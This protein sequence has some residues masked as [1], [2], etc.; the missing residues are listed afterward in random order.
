MNYL[1]HTLAFAVGASIGAAATYILVKRKY[2]KMASE[3]IEAMKKHYQS[4]DEDEDVVENEEKEEESSEPA[5]PTN[6]DDLVNKMYTG[7]Y[8]IES[9]DKPYI[10]D[11]DRYHSSYHGYDKVIL[12]YYEEDGTL[13]DDDYVYDDIDYAIGID[14]L[15]LFDVQDVLYIRNPHGGYDAEVRKNPG[16]YDYE[17]R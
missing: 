4:K 7:K 5:P 9:T 11:E 12:T 1:T 8:P 10:I 15:K 17:N 6:Y 2:E 3:D 14:N 16:S 13:A